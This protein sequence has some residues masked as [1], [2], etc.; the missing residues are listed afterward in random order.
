MLNKNNDMYSRFDFVG[1]PLP[2]DES[3][4]GEDHHSGAHGPTPRMSC[5]GTAGGYS[6]ETY[7]AIERLE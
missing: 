5:L 4:S 2:Q 1:K 3:D 6:T 7:F